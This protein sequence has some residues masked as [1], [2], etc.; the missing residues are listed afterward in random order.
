MFLQQLFEAIEK[1]HASFCFGRMNPP[2]LGHKQL[3]DTVANASNGGDYYVFVSQTQDPKKNP[4]DYATKVKFIKALVPEHAQHVVYDTSLK[5]IIQ[6][7]HWL[8]AKGYKS[9]TFVAGSDRI[10]NFRELL[11]KYNGVEG[12]NGFYK[13]DS[14]NVVSSGDR[15]PDADGLAGISA[16]AAREAAKA[17]DL[18]AFAQATGAGKLAQPLYDAVR[19]GMGIQDQELAVAEHIIKHGSGYRL[20]SKKTGKNLGDFPTKAAAE[21]HERE[22][23][24]FKHLDESEDPLEPGYYFYEVPDR[25]AAAKAGLRQTH[26]GEWHYQ[27]KDPTKY[28][29]SPMQAKLDRMAVDRA[30]KLFGGH[31][32]WAPVAERTIK[33]I[34]EA[35]P[36]VYSN[37]VDATINARKQNKKV[38]KSA[39]GY[40]KVTDKSDPAKELVPNEEYLSKQ[41]SIIARVRSIDAEINKNFKAPFEQ[42]RTELLRS[43]PKDPT[44]R[45]FINVDDWA[46]GLR[47]LRN[48]YFSKEYNALEIEKDKLR[49]NLKKLI[50]TNKSYIELSESSGYIPKNKKEAKDP[51]WSNALTVDVHPDT[52][53]KNMKALGL[54]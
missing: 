30:D 12:P 49:A 32:Y 9:V 28:N 38:V 31:K 18:E 16:T 14:I 43:L 41:R 42:E 29:L 48:T 17:G 40:F 26:K 54:I 3:I 50:A 33:N 22:V 7:A 19:K 25:S 51:R 4:L 11:N 24:Y 44:T 45:E 46:N 52:P 27:V 1:K 23:G 39:G 2:T 20:V 6:I 15:D 13:F 53:N 36:E 35:R 21:K 37:I 8:Y 5:T 47:N 10:D 34:S